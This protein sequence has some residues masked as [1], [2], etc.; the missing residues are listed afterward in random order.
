MFFFYRSFL[1]FAM[2]KKSLLKILC[3]KGIRKE[4][5]SKRETERNT[6]MTEVEVNQNAAGSKW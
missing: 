3:T 4:I 6:E 2:Q 1:C 5:E